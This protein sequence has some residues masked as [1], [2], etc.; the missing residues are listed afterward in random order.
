VITPSRTRR[1]QSR[2]NCPVACSSVSIALVQPSLSWITPASAI[3]A[4]QMRYG[5]PGQQASKIARGAR[6][7]H[8]YEHA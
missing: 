8:K 1:S 2:A 6:R 3:A 5:S 4:A 7:R